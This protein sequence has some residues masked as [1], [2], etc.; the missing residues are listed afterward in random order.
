MQKIF[1]Q[2]TVLNL[3]EHDSEGYDNRIRFSEIETVAT[4]DFIQKEI[5]PG[6]NRRNILIWGAE[7]ESMLF[8]FKNNLVHIKA[9]GGLVQN[10]LGQILFIFRHGKWDLPKGKPE[11]GENIMATAIRE[12]EEECGVSKLSILSSL[13]TTFHIYRPH[14]GD[15][16]LKECIWFHMRCLGWK[17]LKVQQEEG[18]TEARWIAMPVPGA[19]MRGAFPSIKSLVKFFQEIYLRDLRS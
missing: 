8:Y 6:V 1:I 16:A 11:K 10:P 17:N 15:F 14:N 19:I 4:K 3:S 7:E 12:V 5:W 2:N 9:G 18:I 13:P